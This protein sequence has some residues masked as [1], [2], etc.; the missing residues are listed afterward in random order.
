M[1]VDEKRQALTVYCLGI[2]VVLLDKVT[3]E[4][5]RAVED[6][7]DIVRRLPN[8]EFMKLWPDMLK[9]GE[10]FTLFEKW[11]QLDTPAI[12]KMLKTMGLDPSVVH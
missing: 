2:M 9:R 8:S 7:I 12:E 3:P 5:R 1:T 10:P 11:A 4:D 6:S